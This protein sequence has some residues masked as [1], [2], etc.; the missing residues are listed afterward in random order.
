[1]RVPAALL[2]LVLQLKPL[3]GA[4]VCFQTPFPA[5]ECPMPDGRGGSVPG[6]APAPLPHDFGHG[7]PAPACPAADFCAAAAPAIGAVATILAPL[8]STHATAIRFVLRLHSTEPVAPPAP[9]PN[10]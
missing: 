9:P 4:L 10:A 7:A 8:L 2:L 1:M 6:Q 3:V 5:S